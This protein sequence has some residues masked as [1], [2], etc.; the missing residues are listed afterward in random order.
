MG[1]FIY[2][3]SNDSGCALAGFDEWNIFD[4]LENTDYGS[5]STIVSKKTIYKEYN[6]NKYVHIFKKWKDKNGNDVW[7]WFDSLCI[8]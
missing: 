3:Y 8:N 4:I 1:R 5:H 7:R 6:D 2:L